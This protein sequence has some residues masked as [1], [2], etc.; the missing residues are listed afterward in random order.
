MGLVAVA[1]SL[2]G[3]KTRKVCFTAFFF[4]LHRL[5]LRLEGIKDRGQVQKVNDTRQLCVTYSLLVE[6]RRD[7]GMCESERSQR[8]QRGA[9]YGKSRSVQ[10]SR[11]GQKKNLKLDY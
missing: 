4:V 1:V 5:H 11:R 2:P 9:D 8:K 6:T 7:L 10:L 3:A